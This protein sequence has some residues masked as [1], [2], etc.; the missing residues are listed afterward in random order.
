MSCAVLYAISACVLWYLHNKK[1]RI[2]WEVL[3]MV[4]CRLRNTAQFNATWTA[5]RFGKLRWLANVSHSLLYESLPHRQ[6]IWITSITS[7]L[8]FRGLPT[9]I[10]ASLLLF[11]SPVLNSC[12]GWTVLSTPWYLKFTIQVVYILI[13]MKMNQMEFMDQARW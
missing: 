10:A 4:A 2:L 8:T 12:S 9:G 13:F 6:S 5:G 3:W 7:F 11:A 1:I